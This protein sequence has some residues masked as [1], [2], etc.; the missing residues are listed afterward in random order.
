MHRLALQRHGAASLKKKIQRYRS[1]F[2]DLF[3]NHRRVE[4]AKAQFSGYSFPTE[5]YSDPVTLYHEICVR[6][7][8]LLEMGQIHMQV[9][10]A[11]A[12]TQTVAFILMLEGRE[13]WTPELYGEMSQLFS[14][15]NNI[16]SADV[17]VALKELAT[18]IL[19]EDAGRSWFAQQPTEVATAWLQSGSGPAGEL[20]RTFLARHGHRSIKVSCLNDNQI[21]I[22][23]SRLDC[24]SNF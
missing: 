12:T 1:L 9:S 20:F 4:R 11:S 8:E 23:E 21:R 13:E 18:A 5:A 10:S 22:C 7:P 24:V 3:F 14:S 2:V 6:L 17:P 15:I 16:E 19:N